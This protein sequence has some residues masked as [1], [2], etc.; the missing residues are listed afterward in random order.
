MELSNTNRNVPAH[1]GL[2]DL[3]IDA[4]AAQVRPARIW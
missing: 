3:T 2:V 4:P 1:H